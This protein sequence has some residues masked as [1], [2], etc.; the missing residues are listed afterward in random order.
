M[1]PPLTL[2]LALALAVGTVARGQEDPGPRPA[3]PEPADDHGFTWLCFATSV[4][5]LGGLY[6]LVRRREQA[7]EAAHRD[8]RRPAA[9]WYCRACSR[10]VSGPE[11]P[12]CGTPNPFLHDAPSTDTGPRADSRSKGGGRRR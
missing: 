4:T 6:V 2:A 12:A 7:V 8:G 11:C 1:R 3:G 9:S 10:D 5:V